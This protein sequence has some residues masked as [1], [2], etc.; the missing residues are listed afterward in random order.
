MRV[1]RTCA[2]SEAV[3]GCDSNAHYIAECFS[4][5]RLAKPAGWMYQSSIDSPTSVVTCSSTSIEHPIDT[6][7]RGFEVRAYPKPL[8]AT[9]SCTI[10]RTSYAT[11]KCN[12]LLRQK[13]PNAGGGAT[14]V[15]S[16]SCRIKCTVKF[17]FGRI[18]LH[19]R[20]MEPFLVN[21]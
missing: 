9:M 10:H 7:R 11:T 3:K 21:C 20:V 14:L 8:P 18:L 17:G 15:T 1:D 12:T 4:N 16:G 6:N 2:P 13:N 19:S 5:L